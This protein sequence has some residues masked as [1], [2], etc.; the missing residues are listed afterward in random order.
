MRLAAFLLLSVTGAALFA[1]DPNTL[2]AEEKR[3][4]FRLLFDGK[5]F[6]N[7]KDP[8]KKDVP[9]S[10]WTIEDGTLKTVTKGNKF[11]EDLISDK[12]YG[13]F[14]LRFDWRMNKA[15]NTG[16][17]Y[18]I[19]KEIFLEEEKVAAPRF[20]QM[21]GRELLEHKSNRKTYTGGRA[22][23][24]TVGF[25]FQLL[26]D[27]NHPDGKKDASHR[28]GA[29]Y[30]FIAPNKKAAKPVG[31]WNSA[32]LVVQGDHFEHWLNGVLVLEGSLKD[33]AVEEGAKKRWG[34][35]PAIKDWLVNAKPTGSI[36]L[37]HHGDEVWFRSIRIHELPASK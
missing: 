18:R 37:Q 7:W 31:E 3:A 12:N 36:A 10:A 34:P 25:E 19:Q 16:L 13:N 27:D 9:N 4:G 6:T 28:T 23:V 15:G 17:K 8:A 22:Q 26:D 5:T 21:M 2:N 35:A 20:E 11:S 32:R 24:Y 1:A 33:K 29:L 30:S 14:E